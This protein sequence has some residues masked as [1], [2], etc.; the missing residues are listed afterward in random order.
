M[1]NPFV[2]I[3]PSENEKFYGNREEF[4]KTIID[5]IETNSMVDD[6]RFIVLTGGYGSGKTFF[7]EK[8][9]NK[10]EK[11]KMLSHILYFSP[12]LYEQLKEDIDLSKA[13]KDVLLIVDRFEFAEYLKDEYVKKVIKLMFEML[14]RQKVIFLISSISNSWKKLVR[15][16][17]E[18]KASDV[19]EVPGLS[20]EEAMDLVRS[21]L[22]KA[23]VKGLGPFAKDEIKKIW[24]DSGGNPRMI[25]L[26]CAEIYEDKMKKKNKK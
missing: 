24:K 6:N 1:A 9:K 15:R 12:A 16:Y 3:V 10:V 5:S 17:P 13:K 20:F 7:L 4:F 26:L 19:Y 2:S 22:T 25:L 21:R 23:K 14:N 8:I 18:L 11:N